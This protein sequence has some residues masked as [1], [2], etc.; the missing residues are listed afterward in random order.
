MYVCVL[1][2][3]LSFL[4][5][6]NGIIEFD[7]NQFLLYK[8]QSTCT[9]GPEVV[10]QPTPSDN[11]RECD[12]ASCGWR[13]VIQLHHRVYLL[14]NLCI[15]EIANQL[16]QGED[17]TQLITDDI[18]QRIYHAVTKKDANEIFLEHFRSKTLSSV[19][20][21]CKILRQTS[22]DYEVADTKHTCLLYTSPSPRDRQK[23]RM[24]SS[25]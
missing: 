21:F 5:F 3:I 11:S 23:S 15:K 17:G 12:D 20:I 22:R 25:A 7:G 13:K 8:D 19:D 10:R 24:P 14:E 2:F 4:Q 6:A 16:L 18:Y 1:F 9:G